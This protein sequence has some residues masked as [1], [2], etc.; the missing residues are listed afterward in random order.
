VV[1]VGLDWGLRFK[2][3]ALTGWRALPIPSNWERLGRLERDEFL[4]RY[5]AK[6]V[7]DSREP[8]VTPIGL[9]A[10]RVECP[11]PLQKLAPV[12]P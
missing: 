8:P 5:R 4:R 11:L 2:F 6:F 7:V 1:F 9:G 10:T 12:T 3:G